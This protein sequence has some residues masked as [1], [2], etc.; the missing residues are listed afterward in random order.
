MKDLTVIADY[1]VICSGESTTQV[2]TIAEHI[3]ENLLE[4][5]IAPLR[6]EGFQ[7]ARWVL[8][9]Y[10]DAIIHVFEEE[11][12]QYYELEKLWLDAPR[13]TLSDEDKDNMD[14][15]D[16]RAISERRDSAVS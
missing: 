15:E 14:R 3:R 4:N 7:Y 13:I 8:I 11:T 9:D 6:I 1:F 10:G 5:G 12:R 16:E 2:K